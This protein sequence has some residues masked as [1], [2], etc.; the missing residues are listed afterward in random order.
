MA[1]RDEILAGLDIG[2]TKVCAVVAEIRDNELEVIGVGT[3]PSRGLS[4]GVVVNI[5]HTV[6]AIKH[7]LYEVETMSGV[8]V[9]SVYAGIA[10]SHIKGFN[11]TG[12]IAVKNGEIRDVDIHRV[13][14][15]ARAVPLPAD[16]EIVHILPQDFIVD[17]QD[18][19]RDP[20]GMSAVR[21]EARVHIVTGLAASVQNIMKS[22]HRSGLH[23]SDIVLTQIASAE[24]VLTPDERELG[25]ALFDIGG[26]TCDIAIYINGAIRH[27]AVVPIAGQHITKDVAQGLRTP[28]QEAEKVKIQHGCAKVQMVGEDEMIEVSGVGGRPPRRVERK[29]LAQIIEPRV[30]ELFTLIDGELIRSG[31]KNLLA[32]GV[33]ITGGTASLPGIVEV[34]EQVLDLPARVGEPSG[35]GG[36]VDMV[37]DPRFATPIGLVL[38]GSKYRQFGT[39]ARSGGRRGMGE[40]LFSR[41]GRGV[42]ETF[43]EFF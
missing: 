39:A 4:R 17:D 3:A 23:V 40:G 33:V 12:L 8:K 22:C 19:V 7:A 32:A 21:L 35:V 29:T 1:K 15:A 43:A 25:V 42:K 41:F 5:E 2:T 24:A 11:S 10:G 16:R 34:A 30:D 13:V 37:H 27:T 26:G 18:N 36:L 14:E 6:E 31:F 9:E 20:L 28:S 38:Y